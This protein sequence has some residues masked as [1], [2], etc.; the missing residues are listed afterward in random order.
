MRPEAIRFRLFCYF[1][2]LHSMNTHRKTMTFLLLILICL[3]NIASFPQQLPVSPTISPPPTKKGS[4]PLQTLDDLRA[5][6]RSRMLA[7][8]AARGRVGI[9]ITSLNSGKVVFENDSEKYFIPASNM[10]NFTVAAAL[11]KLGPDFR[12]VTSVYAET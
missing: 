8:E 2:K 4:T 12:F 11:E 6:I 3:A 1:C 5:K 9:K 7:P 10:K